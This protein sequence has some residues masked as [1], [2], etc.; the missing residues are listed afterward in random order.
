MPI[1][2]AL[3]VF[4]LAAGAGAAWQRQ[5]LTAKQA[6]IDTPEPHPLAYFTQ[7]PMLREQTG[8]FCYLCSPAKRLEEAK[9]HDVAV[10]ITRVGSIAGFEG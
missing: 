7:Y 2:T 4:L 6:W 10:E 1:R 3:L 9:K 5:V 8:D